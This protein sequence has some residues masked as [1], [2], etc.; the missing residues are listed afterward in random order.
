MFKRA[1]IY[2][3]GGLRCFYSLVSYGGESGNVFATP[4][5]APPERKRGRYAFII[6]LL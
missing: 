2:S 3:S 5:P 1:V 4:L 6:L